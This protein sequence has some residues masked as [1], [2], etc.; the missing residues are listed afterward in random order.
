MLALVCVRVYSSENMHTNPNYLI[1]RGYFPPFEANGRQ[2]AGWLRI[3]GA[4]GELRLGHYEK[5]EHAGGEMAKVP[6]ILSKQPTYD[7]EHRALSRRGH[8][9]PLA[10]EGLIALDGLV[11]SVSGRHMQSHRFY[12]VLNIDVRA[13]L[14]GDFTLEEFIEAVGPEH[15]PDQE[16]PLPRL[17]FSQRTMAT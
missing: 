12:G 17:D 1:D 5:P 3:G 11:R 10:F 8:E 2:S 16:Y 7:H 6:L 4:Y 9:V 15:Q 13:T 14:L